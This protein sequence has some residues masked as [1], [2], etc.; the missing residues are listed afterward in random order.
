[1]PLVRSDVVYSIYEDSE[2]ALRIKIVARSGQLLLDCLKLVTLWE[3][4]TPH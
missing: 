2:T 3:V 4:L 1:M